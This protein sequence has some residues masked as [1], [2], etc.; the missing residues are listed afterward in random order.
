MHIFW[1][2][3]ARF[4]CLPLGSYGVYWVE[5]LPENADKPFVFDGGVL[6]VC[7][8]SHRNTCVIRSVVVVGTD[9]P[10]SKTLRVTC[11]CPVCAMIVIRGGQSYAA[12]I[13]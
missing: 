13:G 9:L 12:A 11:V 1:L 10:V 8:P 2:G 5:M 3:T 4:I 7:R 6:C